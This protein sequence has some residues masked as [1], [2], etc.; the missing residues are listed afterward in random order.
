LNPAKRVRVGILGVGS[1]STVAHIPA[2][3]EEPG[4]EPIVVSRRDEDAGR[5][6]A[7]SYGFEHYESDW[8]AALRYDLDAVIVNSPPVAHV[9]Q[10]CGALEA[11]AHV[12]C[13]K[14]FALNEEDA[15]IMLEASRRH[16]KSLLVGFGWNQHP[17]VEKTRELL[18]NGE[19][20]EFSVV[21][22]T[23][24][25]REL[26]TSGSLPE[27]MRGREF[28][29]QPATYSNQ[30]VSGGGSLLANASHAFGMMVRLL[31]ADVQSIA[32]H[33]FR[34]TQGLDLHDAIWVEYS[35][36]QQVNLTVVSVHGQERR[37]GWSWA[38]YG[39]AGTLHLDT[40]AG[41]VMSA[42]PLGLV[43]RERPVFAEG[44]EKTA[45]TK[46]LIETARGHGTFPELDAE[47][48]SNVVRLTQAASLSLQRASTVVLDP[49]RSL[50]G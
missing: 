35:G 33:A 45:P 6:I 39:P 46:S 26:F 20:P 18:L 47:L 43:R 28:P 22:L 8:R 41:Q 25:T 15:A 2:L 12:L 19:A 44:I 38:S 30:S 34:G 14:P 3:L 13:E 42:D 24:A 49:I 17:L 27:Y 36:G 16:K 4:V 48:A 50:E 31:G 7:K 40:Q 32:G 37:V 23:V 10:V 21:Q 5:R 1:W 11:G 29:P 9:A